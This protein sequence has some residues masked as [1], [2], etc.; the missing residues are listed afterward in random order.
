[1]KNETENSSQKVENSAHS[2]TEDIVGKLIFKIDD[3]QKKLHDHN[4]MCQKKL[5]DQMAE[6]IP[7]IKKL[8]D[9]IKEL[10]ASSKT[11]TREEVLDLMASFELS[12]GGTIEENKTLFPRKFEHTKKIAI[13]YLDN[14][15]L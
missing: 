2:Y 5:S 11:Y 13:T 10:E 15:K 4:G 6:V 8:K 1:M 7:E 12:A 14:G 3:L 9:R